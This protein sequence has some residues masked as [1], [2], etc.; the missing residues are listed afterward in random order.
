MTFRDYVHCWVHGLI[1]AIVVGGAIQLLSY[2]L[3]L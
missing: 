3:G 2:T 1:V